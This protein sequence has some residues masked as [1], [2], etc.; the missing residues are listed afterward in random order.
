ML[1]HSGS[2]HEIIGAIDGKSDG[3]SLNGE[4]DAVGTVVG[5]IFIIGDMVGK[6]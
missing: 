5:G 1:P 6:S 4:G 2:S 3:V